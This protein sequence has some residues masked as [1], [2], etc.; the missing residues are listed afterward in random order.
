MKYMHI[1]NKLIIG[2]IPAA[3]HFSIE[4]FELL[5][6]KKTVTDKSKT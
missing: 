3:V 2:R 1:Y 4:Y 5:E 6:K